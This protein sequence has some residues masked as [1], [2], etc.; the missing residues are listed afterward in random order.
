MAERVDVTPVVLSAGF[1]PDWTTITADGVAVAN[2]QGR[3]VVMLRAVTAAQVTIQT[4]LTR[5]GLALPDKVLTIAA[6]DEWIE[7]LTERDVYNVAA[8]QAVLI[9]SNQIDTEILAVEFPY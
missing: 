5:A 7:P 3:A 9:D 6:G 2:A 1:E 8:S 4:H